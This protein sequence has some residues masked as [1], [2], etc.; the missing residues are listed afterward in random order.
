[1]KGGL[2]DLQF[3]DPL[4]TDQNLQPSILILGGL[5]TSLLPTKLGT[6]DRPDLRKAAANSCV[7]KTRLEF[8]SFFL[9]VSMTEG[10]KG[11]WGT[12]E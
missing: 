12:L 6:I 2:N 5:N 7:N 9:S 1:M 4:V 3:L 10:W 8:Q 11:F